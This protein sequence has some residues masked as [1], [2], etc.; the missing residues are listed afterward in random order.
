MGRPASHARPGAQSIGKS[1]VKISESGVIRGMLLKIY[2]T[3]GGSDAG[4]I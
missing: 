4:R 3:A 1:V 2:K